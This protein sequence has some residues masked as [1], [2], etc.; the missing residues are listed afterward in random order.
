M[1]PR[2]WKSYSTSIQIT[3]LIRFLYWIRFICVQTNN[4]PFSFMASSFDSREKDHFFNTDE[5]VQ[6]SAQAPMYL[7]DNKL[8]APLPNL[9]RNEK[10]SW[11]LYSVACS[12]TDTIEVSMDSEDFPNADADSKSK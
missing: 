11:R 3:N 4:E 2:F 7:L 10:T 12:P 8:S 5:E 1:N 6:E 9:R